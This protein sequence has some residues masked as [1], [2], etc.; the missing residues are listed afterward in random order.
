MASSPRSERSV[1]TVA[2]AVLL[3]ALLGALLSLIT[4]DLVRR[5]LFDAWQR[6]AP[7]TIST[8]RVAVVLIDPLSLETV[9]PWPWPR[10]YIAR[11]TEAID[12]QRPKAIGFDVIFAEPDAHNPASFAALYP[13]MDP[14]A[15]AAV[16]ALPAMDEL[17]ATVLGRSPVVLARLGVESDGADPQAVMIDPEVA[18]SPPR[19]TISVPQILASIPELD[20]V[21]KGHAMING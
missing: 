10:Y 17:L 14:A 7:R 3:G 11:L 9:G 6:T 8:D 13:E 20:D 18:G 16:R 19:D 1:R 2:V 5:E 21:A 12:R 4:G 15:A